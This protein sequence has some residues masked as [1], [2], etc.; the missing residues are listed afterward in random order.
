MFL[1]ARVFGVMSFRVSACQQYAEHAVRRLLGLP[2]VDVDALGRPTWQCTDA[3]VS[4]AYRKLSLFVHPDKHGNSDNEKAREAFERLNEAHRILRD[5]AK[6]ADELSQRLQDAK[7]RRAKAEA[8]AC[9]E[10]RLALNAEKGNAVSGACLASQRNLPIFMKC[11]VL[12]EISS[13]MQAVQLRK[14]E[15]HLLSNKLQ[16][17]ARRR[18]EENQ[19]KRNRKNSSAKRKKC[20]SEED[21]PPP[22][23]ALPASLPAAA[24]CL[25]MLVWGPCTLQL[26]TLSLYMVELRRAS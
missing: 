24:R 25:H 5:P 8:N 14:E 12:P 2:A 22:A 7:I 13:W 19:A 20:S 26:Y 16:E 21:A 9:L 4:R 15:E 23:G 1:C 18:Q 3:D 10:E 11:L 17:Q 6:R